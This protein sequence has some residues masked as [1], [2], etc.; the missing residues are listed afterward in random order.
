MLPKQIEENG[1]KK[2]EVT[3]DKRALSNIIGQYTHEAG[4]RQLERE[5]GKICRKVARKKADDIE[6]F[7]SIKVNKDNL[8]D[9][10]RAPKTFPEEAL[11]KD[12]IGVATGLAWTAVGGD[13][14]FIEALR[15]RGK[16]NLVLTG[17]PAK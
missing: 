6:N 15:L 14:L 13:I 1:L 4:L 12:Q 7:K 8:A 3:I 2:G 10:L 11:K 5:I 9:F 17:Q 16:G